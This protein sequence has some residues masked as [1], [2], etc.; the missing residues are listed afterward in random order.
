MSDNEVKN[1]EVDIDELLRQKVKNI[2]PQE[3]V[4]GMPVSGRKQKQAQTKR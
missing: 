4:R 2:K 1:E 3:P